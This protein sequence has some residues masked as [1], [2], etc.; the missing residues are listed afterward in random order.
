MKCL[1]FISKL[2]NGGGSLLGSGQSYRW[3]KIGHKLII[4]KVSFWVY[5]D[6]FCLFLYTFEIFHKQ[7]LKKK[8]NMLKKH[9]F[10]TYI[11]FCIWP[12]LLAKMEKNRGHIYLT[13]ETNIHT[14]TCPTTTTNNS[15]NDNIRKLG[16]RKQKT[17]IFEI[18]E[19]NA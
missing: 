2:S 19:T 12:P 6:S 5:G 7:S 11:S 3:S 4:V 1:Q 9:I 17:M 16:L 14:H 18:W 8:S 10:L 15:N 13:P